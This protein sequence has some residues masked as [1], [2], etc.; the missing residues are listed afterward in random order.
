M[1]ETWPGIRK[2]HPLCAWIRSAAL[3]VALLAPFACPAADEPFA[4]SDEARIAAASRAFSVAYVSGDLKT[5]GE[6][7]THDAVLLP[8]N[9]D[10]LGRDAIREYFTSGPNRKQVAHAMVSIE[11]LVD[12]DTAIDMGTWNSTWQ[13]KD[14]PAQ[15]ASGRYLVVWRRGK[16]GAWRM[17]YDMWHRP[18][19]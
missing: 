13:R 15:S 18:T 11:L 6:L 8:P 10:V 5:L 17:Q 9:R 12:G 7:Y 3:T 16:D 14:E 2:E 19:R 1:S 4:T